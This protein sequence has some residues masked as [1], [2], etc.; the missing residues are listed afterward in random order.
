M[1]TEKR[2]SCLNLG[3]ILWSLKHA[4]NGSIDDIDVIRSLDERPE[5]DSEDC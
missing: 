2:A 3:V 5:Y 1:L 4:L